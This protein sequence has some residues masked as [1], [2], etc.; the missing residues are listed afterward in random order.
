AWQRRKFCAALSSAEMELLGSERHGQSP[1]GRSAGALRS[2][3]PSCGPTT[4]LPTIWH[5]SQNVPGGNGARGGGRHRRSP[6]GAGVREQSQSKQP[7]SWP[8]LKVAYPL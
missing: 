7:S 3:E 1:R 4:K 2:I 8:I 6:A 5:I